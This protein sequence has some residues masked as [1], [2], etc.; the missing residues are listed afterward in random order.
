[1]VSFTIIILNIQPINT[2]NITVP[3]INTMYVPVGQLHPQND[4]AGV[5]INLNVAAAIKRGKFALQMTNTFLKYHKARQVIVVGQYSGE[6]R[7]INFMTIKR[8]KV[9]RNLQTLEADLKSVNK[10]FK[11]KRS[12]RKKK[13][14]SASF[15]SAKPPDKEDR[16][17]SAILRA[18]QHPSMAGHATVL[19]PPRFPP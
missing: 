7:V 9:K 14:Q 15:K 2:K 1:M 3:Q 5:L 10:K 19:I 4:F 11:K 13:R 17:R 18:G 16:M 8:N 12:G 6:D